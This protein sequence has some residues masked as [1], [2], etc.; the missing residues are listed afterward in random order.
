METKAVIGDK[1]Y[2]IP[3]GVTQISEDG[4]Y[5]VDFNLV[6]LADDMDMDF[7]NPRHLG[8]YEND[9]KTF[10]GQGF[11]AEDMKELLNDISV[12]GLDYPLLTRWILKDDVVK[13]QVYDGERRWRC[14]DRLIEQDTKVWSTEHQTMLPAKEV[15][16]YIPC[17]IK[18]MSDDEA[19]QRAC[20]VSQTAV[21]WGDAALARLIKKEYERG[22]D[23][24]AICKLLNKG[25]QWVRETNMLN[26]L[27]EFCFNYLLQGKVNRAVA[28]KLLKIEDIEE[29]KRLCELTYTD[30]VMSYATTVQKAEVALEKSEDK[31]ELVEA[32]LEEAKLNNASPEELEE[33]EADVQAAKEKTQKRKQ[34]KAASARPMG[35][36]KN[37]RNAGNGSKSVTSAKVN[38]QLKV[39]KE[40]IEKNDETYGPI[41]ILKAIVASLEALIAGEDIMEALKK[42]S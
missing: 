8:N 40:L 2:E 12:A 21:K 26:D 31:E 14:V 18:G 3:E 35:K 1:E 38:K 36:S 32:E 37:L 28:K 33:L 27:D 22:K 20:A 25:S 23:D 30:A 29:R 6:A 11:N 4:L 17:R 5:L 19:M 24:A 10:L 7:F 13:L 42:A 41:N 15:Y 16:K 9:G 39:I 34:N